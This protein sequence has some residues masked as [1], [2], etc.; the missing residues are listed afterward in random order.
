MCAGVGGWDNEILLDSYQRNKTKQNK[1]KPNLM[2][3]EIKNY[4][5]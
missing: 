3:Y 5:Q 4:Q 2:A 1:T